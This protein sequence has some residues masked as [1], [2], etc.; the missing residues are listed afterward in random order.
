MNREDIQ[1]EKKSTLVKQYPSDPSH[2]EFSSK[3]PSLKSKGNTDSEDENKQYYLDSDGDMVVLSDDDDF[4]AALEYAHSKGRDLI[5]VQKFAEEK[6]EELKEQVIKGSRS[7]LEL[8]AETVSNDGDVDDED[9]SDDGDIEE[10]EYGES[11]MSRPEEMNED[12]MDQELNKNIMDTVSRS[13]SV[14]SKLEDSEKAQEEEKGLSESVEQRSLSCNSDEKIENYDYSQINSIENSLAGNIYAEFELIGSKIGESVAIGRGV[15]DYQPIPE[16][17]KHK[18]ENQEEVIEVKHQQE[19]INFEENKNN[20]SQRNSSVQES[21]EEQE[22][23]EMNSS[24]EGELDKKDVLIQI[25]AKN[26]YNDPEEEEKEE[27]NHFEDKQR[28][29]VSMSV[30]KADIVKDDHKARVNILQ[31]AIESVNFIFQNPDKRFKIAQVDNTE[32]EKSQDYVIT[33]K[34]GKIAKKRWRVINNSSICW[35]KNSILYCQQEE[36]EVQLP[37]IP[38]SL[39]PGEKMD[40]SVN[41][42]IS[43]DETKNTVKVYVFR[44]YS[45]L[46]GEFGEPLIATVEITPDFVKSPLDKLAQDDKLKEL[47]EGDDFNPILYEIANDFVEEGLGNFER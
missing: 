2:P 18:I 7:G 5:V 25:S 29:S 41:I 12:E 32:E 42:K 30:A 33:C 1:N 3:L 31:K 27:V 6:K 23:M 20:S 38:V 35:P 44:L 10:I 28:V 46:Y 21:N 34:P 19:E 11:T 8:V 15:Q 13:S 37:K 45:K 47:L 39:K 9:L 24:V 16:V 22:L 4:E 26:V 17:A 40:L 43:E 14:Y 36:A